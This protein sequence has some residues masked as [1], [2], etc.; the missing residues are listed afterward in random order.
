MEIFKN[1][2]KYYNEIN[3]YYKS[4][5]KYCYIIIKNISNINNPTSLSDIEDDIRTIIL[6]NGIKE[7]D[8]DD[9][10]DG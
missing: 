10:E 3:E 6:H 4:I 7:D 8:D 2:E 1:I 5:K 9:Y